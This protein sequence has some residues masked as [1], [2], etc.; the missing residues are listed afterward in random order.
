VA[1][2]VAVDAVPLTGPGWAVT[3]APGWRLVPGPRVGDLQLSDGGSIAAR[4][5]IGRSDL[6]SRPRIG[7]LARVIA[8]A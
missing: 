4:C 5:G 7:A 3:L 6:P 1:A 2:P 8:K